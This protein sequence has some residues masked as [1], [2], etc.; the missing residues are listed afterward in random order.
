MSGHRRRGLRQRAE[1]SLPRSTLRIA[2]AMATDPATKNLVTLFILF[3]IGLGGFIIV[4]WYRRNP[5][6]SGDG[7]DSSVPILPGHHRR[8]I[9]F[10]GFCWV[11]MLCGIL[12]YGFGLKWQL[13]A[14]QVA[15]ELF[16][17]IAFLCMF[18]TIHL[19]NTAQCPNCSCTMTQ[20][21][22]QVQRTSDGIFV[23]PQC[24]GR[25][26]TSAKWGFR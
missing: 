16:A 22:N 8:A 25:W 1:T 4:Q 12:L 13:A 6:S 26:R 23:C 7:S 14:V 3:A 18:G 15:G 2:S 20:G 11:G 10:F 9:R 17:F 21:W 5:A 19:V 24:K